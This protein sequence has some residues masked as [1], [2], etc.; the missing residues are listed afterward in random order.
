MILNERQYGALQCLL[1]QTSTIYTGPVS[2]LVLDDHRVL[3]V[4]LTEKR[5][6][7]VLVA[8]NN[9]KGRMDDAGDASWR[10]P[11]DIIELAD[12]VAVFYAPAWKPGTVWDRSGGN[13][14][15]TDYR[16]LAPVR[17]CVKHPTLPGCWKEIRT[18]MTPAVL[19]ELMG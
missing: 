19:Q 11:M 9:V 12:A 10:C 6:K 7:L 5:F 4:T 18:P 17:K 15:K 16:R 14:L 13:P 2:V 3:H 8:E 1:E